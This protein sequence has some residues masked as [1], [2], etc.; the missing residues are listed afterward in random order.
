MVR[1]EGEVQGKSGVCVEEGTGRTGR[2]GRTE[3]LGPVSRVAIPRRGVARNKSVPRIPRVPTRSGNLRAASIARFA[4]R[5]TLGAWC[6]SAKRPASEPLQRPT[7]HSMPPSLTAVIRRNTFQGAPRIRRVRRITALKR[8]ADRLADDVALSLVPIRPSGSR[9]LGTDTERRA[10]AGERCLGNPAFIDTRA[11]AVPSSGQRVP[12]PWRTPRFFII[13]SHPAELRLAASAFT[14]KK[15]GPL[16][17]GQPSCLYLPTG[18]T[19]HRIATHAPPV[20]HRFRT[21]PPT[22]PHRTIPHFRSPV[23]LRVRKNP[24]PPPRVVV[25]YNL[26]VGPPA[27]VPGSE[28]LLLC[29]TFQEVYRRNT[30]TSLHLHKQH[31]LLFFASRVYQHSI[32]SRSPPRFLRAKNHTHP[33]A[34]TETR[35]R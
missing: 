14:K 1:Y 13:V 11:L 4:G 28:W 24:P 23:V 20:P 26:N 29:F 10:A 27:P 6:R 34:Y 18:S 8:G 12:A 25:S 33:V 19:A 31:S 16:V 30:Y 3:I 22:P 9:I 15:S 2:T 7:T 35:D 21:R 17:I 5:A 32:G